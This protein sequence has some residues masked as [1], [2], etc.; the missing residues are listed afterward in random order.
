MQ[1]RL[2][3]KRLIQPPQEAQELLM[4]VPGHAFP[5]YPPVQDIEGSKEGRGPVPFVVVGHGPAAPLLHGQPRL[6]ALQGLDLALFIHAQDDSL[7][8]GLR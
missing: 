1:R 7:V 2:P 3:G 6:R 8:G 4:P 5:D